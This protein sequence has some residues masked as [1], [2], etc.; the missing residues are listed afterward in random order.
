MGHNSFY[1][2]PSIT[3][4]TD[5]LLVAFLDTANPAVSPEFA[6][7]AGKLTSPQLKFHHFGPPA[8]AKVA[9]H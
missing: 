4:H 3:R 2:V 1:V 5:F 7:S 9:H 8:R 6:E